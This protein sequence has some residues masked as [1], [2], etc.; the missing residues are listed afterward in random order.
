MASLPRRIGF[1]GEE[2]RD[3]TLPFQGELP[4]LRAKSSRIAAKHTNTPIVD[5][6]ADAVEL[7]AT[8]QDNA[9]GD[10]DTTSGHQAFKDCLQDIYKEVQFSGRLPTKAWNATDKKHENWNERKD[11]AA[12]ATINSIILG[13]SSGLITRPGQRQEDNDS[14][15]S[16]ESYPPRASRSKTNEKDLSTI[17]RKFIM[18]LPYCLPLDQ[19]FHVTQSNNS[20]IC[21]CP[22]GKRVAPW[23]DARQVH[24]DFVCVRNKRANFAPN[25]L[26]D[27]LKAIGGVYNKHPLF[28]MFHYSAAEYL[29][30]LYDKSF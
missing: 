10:D 24:L 30:K 5:I 7:N 13:L 12:K 3:K 17:E 9:T 27:H 15:C 28:C 23:R 6:S 29:R 19:G 14:D 18:A 1:T 11:R 2:K 22:C 26:M 25:A 21:F 20:E 4:P 16:D 8:P